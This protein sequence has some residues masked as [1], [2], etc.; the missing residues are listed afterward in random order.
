MSILLQANML[1]KFTCL[2]DKCADTCCRAWSMQLDEITYEKYKKEAPELLD[3]VEEAVESPY[4][5]RKDK[6][7]GY[8]VK[9]DNGWCGIHK[10]KGDKFLG[11]ACYFYPRVTRSL[12][13][14][15][16]MTATL[17]CPEIVRIVLEEKD[18][19][20]VHE[21]Q[22]GR[23]PNTL[24][25][26]LPEGLSAQDAL[27]VHQAFLATTHDKDVEAGHIFARIATVSRS[28]Q[29]ID[30]KSWAQAV[31][32]YLQNADMRMM[33]PEQNEADP[34]NLLHAL[35]G[36]IV[37]SHKPMPDRLAQTVSTMEKM[38]KVTLDWKN[39]LIHT[40]D[41]SV[42]AYQKI[43]KAWKSHAKHFEPVLKRYLEAQLAVSLFPF[44]GLGTTLEDRITIIGVRLATVKLALM[45]EHAA[46]GDMLPQDTIIRVVQSLSRLLDHLGDPGF[47][48]AIYKETGWVREE[49][50]RGLL[51]I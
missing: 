41:E 21:V 17:S 24:K 23:L 3:A 47:S 38:L 5:M 14:D 36:L 22:A 51:S 11:D 18:P 35:S 27:S 44:S 50:L 9:Y 6:A 4:I 49:R 46:A 2:G 26:Y 25:N 42:A 33:P 29:L 10:E 20:G 43:R 15:T 37:A 16:V 31:P 28:I 30:K 45:C 7:T 12:G 39:V 48:M 19:F 8:C 32:F 1:G 40:S 13:D 34:F